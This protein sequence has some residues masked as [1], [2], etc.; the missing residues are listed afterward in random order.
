MKRTTLTVTI[1]FACALVPLGA[2]AQETAGA[3]RVEI[4]AFPDYRLFAVKSTDSAPEFFGQTNTRYGHR[5]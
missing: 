2:T 4:G 1:A 5:V 3:G